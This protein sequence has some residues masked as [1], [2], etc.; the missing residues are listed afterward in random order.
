MESE[1]KR[2]KILEKNG[3]LKMP[4]HY[5]IRRRFQKNVAQNRHVEVNLTEVKAKFF[6]S[7]KIFKI[8]LNLL[9]YIMP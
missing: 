6:P 3:Y 1:Y 9:M 2:F 5:I 4:E 8:F 7:R